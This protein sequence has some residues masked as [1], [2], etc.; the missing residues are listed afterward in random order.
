M[1]KVYEAK[2]K[3]EK[4]RSGGAAGLGLATAE[5][6]TKEESDKAVDEFDF[7]RYSLHTPKAVEINHIQREI[8]AANLARKKQAQPAREVSVDPLRIDPHLV[9]FNEAEPVAADEF[10]KLAGSLIAAKADRDLKRLL[11]ASARHGEGRTTVSLNLACTLA[12]A[13]K[14]VLL[15]D[16]DFR[17]PSVTRLLGIE[18]DLG[19]AEAAAQ[20]KAPGEAALKIQPH[21]FVVLPSRG[22]V[23]NPAELIVSNAFQDMLAALDPDYEFILF[24][25]SPLLS[26]NDVAL[27]KRLTS[28]TLLVIKAG[29]TTS[30]DLGK[31]I[32]PLTQEDLFG[33]VLNRVS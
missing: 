2:L 13:G 28:A 7:I 23:D 3:S 22:R 16:T 18:A 4:E 32:G 11:I 8:E 12:R 20:K 25:S 6:R 27:L 29:E 21:G 9:A 24:D 14:S 10:G 31:A 5:A 30:G 33:V 1:G 17:R 19:I 15:V 26:S